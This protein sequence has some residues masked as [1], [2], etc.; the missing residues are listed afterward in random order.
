MPKAASIAKPKPGPPT[1]RHLDIQ[2]IRDD[3]I[4]MKDGTLRSVLAVSSVNFALKSQ[5]E[6]EAIVQAYMS[7][8]NGLE[9]P[10]QIL[11][12]SRRMNIERYITSLREREKETT[13]DLLRRQIVDYQT[14][15]KEL[16]DLGEIMQKRFYVVVPYDPL[17]DTPKG[18]FSRLQEGLS[19]SLGMRLRE[20][21]FQER[22][23]MLMKRVDSVFGQLG[24]MSVNAVVVDTQGLIEL[25]Y[26]SYN[27]DLMGIQKSGDFSKLQVEE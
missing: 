5:E 4:V 12:Q 23:A 13:N 6:Q 2:E 1:Q 25:L 21:Q 14:F 20:E 26:T 18:F 24:S 15:V 10:I 3:V 27:P 9:F 22:K 17:R 19:P 8:L 16:V 7:F 11:I